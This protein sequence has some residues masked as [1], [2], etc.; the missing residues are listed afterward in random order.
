MEYELTI[1]FMWCP[2]LVMHLF[3]NLLK[4]D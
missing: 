2:G 1:P 4:V 3:I